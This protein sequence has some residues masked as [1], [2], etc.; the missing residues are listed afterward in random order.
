MK[1]LL[2]HKACPK[3]ADTS[4]QTP[5]HRGANYINV[6]KILLDFDDSLKTIKDQKGNLPVDLLMEPAAED[7]KLLLECNDH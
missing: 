1:L 5:L 6:V 4:G 7:L 3:V 2:Q